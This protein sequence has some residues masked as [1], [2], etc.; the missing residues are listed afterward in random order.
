VLWRSKRQSVK[1]S[2]DQL[3]KKMLDSGYDKVSTSS[4]KLHDEY[5]KVIN[6]QQG[7]RKRENKPSE[8]LAKLNVK[9]KH[10]DF[11]LEVAHALI[12]I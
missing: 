2:L 11:K 3:L 8:R 4:Q 1:N 6:R 12:D 7:Y 10:A 9:L 5:L